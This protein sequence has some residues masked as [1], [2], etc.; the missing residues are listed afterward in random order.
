ML[1]KWV[2]R[3]QNTGM[4]RTKHHTRLVTIRVPEILHRRL[5]DDKLRNGLS[6]AEWTRS[7][8]AQALRGA[9]QKTKAS[10]LAG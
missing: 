7:L 4:R 2:A 3:G 9:D 5:D 6:L 10:G 8:W 1:A